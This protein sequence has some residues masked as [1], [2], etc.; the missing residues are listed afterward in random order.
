MIYALIHR[1]KGYMYPYNLRLE[2]VTPLFLSV[3][4]Y[5]FPAVLAM[6]DFIS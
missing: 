1:G 3:G 6:H 2:A 5:I 4:D